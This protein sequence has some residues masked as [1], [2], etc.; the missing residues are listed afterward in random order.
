MVTMM[1]LNEATASSSPRALLGK[2]CQRKRERREEVS[3]FWKIF[4]VHRK[5]NL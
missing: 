2:R 5:K 4:N 1:M 3:V